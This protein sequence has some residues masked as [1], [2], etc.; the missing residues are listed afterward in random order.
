MRKRKSL[1][2]FQ[3]LEEPNQNLW[4]VKAVLWKIGSVK[5]MCFSAEMGF[6]KEG[7][8]L[9]LMALCF[10]LFFPYVCYSYAW[11]QL[12]CKPYVIRGHLNAMSFIQVCLCSKL[13]SSF[14]DCQF[15]EFLHSISENVLHSLPVVLVNIILLDVLQLLML[16]VGL[17]YLEPW[18]FLLIIL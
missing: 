14:G 12:N 9:S 18:L 3:T 5:I 6:S 13:S 8:K 1:I 10:I 16:F 15:F 2:F 4:N 7:M 11:E 17:I